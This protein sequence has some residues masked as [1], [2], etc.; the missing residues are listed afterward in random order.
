MANGESIKAE[1]IG[2]QRSDNLLAALA[3]LDDMIVT[4]Q[5]MV[6]TLRAMGKAE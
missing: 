6:D 1:G 4:V 5:S 3:N 2:D